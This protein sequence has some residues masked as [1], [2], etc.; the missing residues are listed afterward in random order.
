MPNLTPL[1]GRSLGA[2]ILVRAEYGGFVDRGLL[3]YQH[4]L[5]YPS[6]LDFYDQ[7][8]NAVQRVVHVEKFY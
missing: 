2:T 4:F 3:H 7:T 8:V 1:S 6:H 5:K